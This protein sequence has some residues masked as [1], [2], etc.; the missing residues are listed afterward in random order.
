MGGREQPMSSI[1][2]GKTEERLAQLG[3][4][5]PAI[6]SPVANYVPYARSGSLVF[7]S[8]QGPQR[9]GGGMHMGKV[10]SDVTVEEAYGHARLV[11]LQLLA[12][13]SAANAGLDAVVRIV[14]VFGMVNCT[15]DFGRHPEVINGC[16]DLLVEVLGDR[17]RHARSAVGM[18]SLPDGI[19]V[20]IEAV[21]EVQVVPSRLAAVK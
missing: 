8:G 9:E 13:L 4:I 15:P 6:R 18:G 14:K 19:T 17:G 16:S 11:G 10:G 20:E 21:A 5:L 1:I 2:M 12:A 7:L 3:L